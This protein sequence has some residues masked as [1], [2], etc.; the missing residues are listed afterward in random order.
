MI[1]PEL[2]ANG[3]P[4]RNDQSQWDD[5]EKAIH[6]AIELIENSGASVLLTDSQF[7][8]QESASIYADWHESIRSG[9][10]VNDID[11]EREVRNREEEVSRN[12]ELIGL[13]IEHCE[14]EE[15]K[16]PN[17]LFESFFGA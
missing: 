15:H 10:S 17:N 2:T 8:L 9:L 6:K 4:R 13:F 7:K 1:K 3:H 16:I 5:V 14:A 12:S 11:E